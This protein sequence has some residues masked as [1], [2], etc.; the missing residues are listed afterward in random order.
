[1]GNPILNNKR[2][3]DFLTTGQVATYCGVNFR[4]VI[5][6]IKRGILEAQRLPGR[7]DHRISRAH[8]LN[9]LEKNGLSIPDDFSSTI[10]PVQNK[11]LASD[12]VD[13]VPLKILIVEDDPVT[14]NAI[15]RVL[16][17]YGYETMIANDGFTAGR[18]LEVF[19]PTLVTLDLLMAGVDG[20][21]VLKTLRSVA[22]FNAIK[23]IV[24]SADSDQKVAQALEIGASKALRKPFQNKELIAAVVE[25]IG[26]PKTAEASSFLAKTK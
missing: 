23:V 14:A 1:M 5:R 24:I 2:T 7:G 18:Q 17:I 13:Q 8:F 26:S 22:R 15:Q 21:S 10:V 20:I 16:K 3:A 12:D 9:F 25:L 6:W 11:S 19:Q 4:T